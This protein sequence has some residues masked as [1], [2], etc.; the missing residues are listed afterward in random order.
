MSAGGIDKPVWN[1]NGS[2]ER[3]FC[4]IN[5]STIS[6]SLSLSLPRTYEVSAWAAFVNF[7][8]RVNEYRLRTMSAE[9]KTDLHYCIRDKKCSY[10]LRPSGV[11]SRGKGRK[12]GTIEKAHLL[13]AR[14]SARSSLAAL[15][16]SNFL[17]P[18]TGSS[19]RVARHTYDSTIPICDGTERS[20]SLADLDAK[21][22]VQS[23]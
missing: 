16:R 22:I 11:V 21:S 5:P 12:G 14:V 17:R 6:L 20:G 13:R 10:T 1:L 7:V 3:R 23:T 15:C 19:A 8:A 2:R 4:E 9:L 18:T